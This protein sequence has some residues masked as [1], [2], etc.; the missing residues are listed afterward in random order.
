MERR[1]VTHP[2]PLVALREHDDDGRFLLQDHLPEVVP[3]FRQRTL[4]GDVLFGVFVSLRTHTHRQL[5]KPE[6]WEQGVL[7]TL[8][9][10]WC[11]VAT[12][13]LTGM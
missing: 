11:A 6:R 8:N 13:P 3:S 9:Q 1:A 12:P 2:P 5:I 4:S 7:S 10:P